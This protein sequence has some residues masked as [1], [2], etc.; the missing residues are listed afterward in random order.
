[1]IS[2]SKWVISIRAEITHDSY[3]CPLVT[4]DVTRRKSTNI[5]AGKMPG[6]TSANTFGYIRTYPDADCKAVV[7]KVRQGAIG[8]EYFRC[9]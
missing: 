6:F 4:M 2:Y 3:F 8:R 7:R 9:Q 5:E 1:M